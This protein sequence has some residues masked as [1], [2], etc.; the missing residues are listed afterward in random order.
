MTTSDHRSREVLLTGMGFC[1]P[2]PK[3]APTRTREEFWGTIASGALHLRAEDSY[4][5]II[6]PPQQQVRDA[7]PEV[8]DAHHASF[9]PVHYYALSA[10][11]TALADAGLDH[12]AGDLAEAAV[13]SARGCTETWFDAYDEFTAGE[14]A[15]LSPGEAMS[16]YLRY[17]V[18][19]SVGDVAN[20]QAALIGSGGPCH[21]VS[22]GCS[23]GL[24]AIADAFRLI[25]DGSAD[26]AVVTGAEH[27]APDRYLRYDAL[28]QR[29]DRA[30]EEGVSLLP[31]G[32][33]FD[34]LSRPYDTRTTGL[35]L[36]SGAVTLVLES[37][38]HAERRGARVYARLAAQAHRRVPGGSAL[39]GDMEGT[40]ATR[41]AH[42][43]LERAGLAPE[44]IDYVQGGADGSNA[45]FSV[46]EAATIRKILG[47]HAK[48][49][50]VSV[51]EA[52]FGHPYA[53]LSLI[54]TAATALMI[55]RGEAC[56]TAGVDQPVDVELDLVLGDEPRPLDIRHALS[57][58]YYLGSGAGALLLSADRPAGDRPAGN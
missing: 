41:A 52:S 34:S 32:I 24:T 48:G 6:D 58:H 51:Q 45:E 56:P 12:A 4:F 18:T 26:V 21:T 30:D 2:G 57:L 36:A 40:A 14:R 9:G 44:D 55:D 13:I 42:W 11:A 33:T 39:G 37:R 22:M 28:R 8:P 16:L 25:A 46:I 3:D 53:A 20:V 31:A 47:D 54:R 35:N 15:D 27:V 38:E 29:G 5:G 50:P 43:C 7:F 10:T 23:S 19:T 17:A 1:L 49:L